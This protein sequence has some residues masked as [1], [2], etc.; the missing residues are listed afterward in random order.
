MV[1]IGPGSKSSRTHRAEE[2]IEQSDV[3]FGYTRYIELAGDLL[4]GKEVISSGMRQEVD[5]CLAALEKANVGWAVAI[6]SSGDPGVYG[7]AGLV[8]ELAHEKGFTFPIEIIAGVSA[9]NAAAAGLGAPLM[10]DYACISLSDLLVPWQQ[11]R[12]RLEKVAEADLVVALY[13]PRSRKRVKQL[14]QAAD[15][16]RKFRPAQ[17]PVGVA[18]SVGTDDEHTVISD[19][20]SFLDLDIGMRSIVIIGNSTSRVYGDIFL[21]QRGYRI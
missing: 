9:A 18:T 16:F 15:I 13:N 5:R 1:G 17:T 10:C 14:C 12:L 7:M 6:L 19:L 4:G 21:T 11:I 8:L 3:V 2:A 20:G